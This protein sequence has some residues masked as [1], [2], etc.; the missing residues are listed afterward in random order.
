MGKKGPLLLGLIAGAVILAGTLSSIGLW[1]RLTN[2]SRLI[3]ES[4]EQLAAI[5]R[6]QQ[7]ASESIS[8]IDEESTNIGT[9]LNL[10]IERTDDIETR[11][12]ENTKRV[13]LSERRI[14]NSII[15]LG[16]SE[17]RV[18]AITKRLSGVEGELEQFRERLGAIE[19]GIGNAQ[20]LAKGSADLIDEIIREINAIRDSFVEDAMG[21]RPLENDSA[22]FQ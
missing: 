20:D 22:S 10:T 8:R 11:L 9:N 4:R 1:R 16:T 7:L 19:N 13:N 21:S 15:R 3:A 12:A 5:E 14:E 18:S 2:S 17:E 6:Q